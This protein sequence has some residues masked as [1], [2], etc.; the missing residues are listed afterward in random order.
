MWYSQNFWWVGQDVRIKLGVFSLKLA[1]KSSSFSLMSQVFRL[2]KRLDKD[3]QH[4]WIFKQLR[5]QI[6]GNLYTGDKRDVTI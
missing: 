6:V 2:N 3:N 4:F 1:T 5:H